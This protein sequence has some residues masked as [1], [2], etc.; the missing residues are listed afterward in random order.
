M[1]ARTASPPAAPRSIG[2]ALRSAGFMA[3]ISVLMLGMGLVGLPSAIVSRDAALGWCKRYARWTLW[4]M[5]VICGTRAEIRGPIPSGSCIV[6]AKHQSFLEVLMLVVALPRPRFV[7][8]Q[9]LLWVPVLGFFARRIGCIAIDRRAGRD[10]VRRMLTD[11][12]GRREEGQIVIFPQGTRVDPGSCA[13]YRGGVLKLYAA[14]DLP[15]ALA[16]INTG[17]FWA[18]KG[19]RRSPGTAVVEFLGTIPPGEP[20]GTLLAR[21]EAEV[22]AGSDRLSAEA[23]ADF[24]TCEGRPG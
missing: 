3:A 6:A 20:T 24:A 16:A 12:A 21:I 14:F 11:A 5:R 8:K 13:P 17:W 23:A 4:L 2:E 1:G 10:A 18:R 7:M 19:L 22:E 15:I 9:S